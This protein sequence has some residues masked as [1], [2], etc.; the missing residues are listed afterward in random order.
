M[1]N[2]IISI[3]LLSEQFLISFK[4]NFNITPN[5]K[6]RLYRTYRLFMNITYM[7]LLYYLHSALYNYC[8][9]SVVFNFILTYLLDK[10][11]HS[12]QYQSFSIMIPHGL[13][14]T[15]YPSL[16]NFVHLKEHPFIYH[17]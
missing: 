4:T 9:T 14:P 1:V 8:Y 11:S 2:N 16:D 6:T 7:I 15:L 10:H 13:L 12:K 17:I 5:Q 3:D